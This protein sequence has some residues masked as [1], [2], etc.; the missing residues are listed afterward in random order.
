MSLK[1][2][3]FPFYKVKNKETLKSVSQK[4]GIDPTTLLLLNNL[5]PKEVKENVILKIKQD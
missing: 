2:L 5:S 3:S 4:F 1:K